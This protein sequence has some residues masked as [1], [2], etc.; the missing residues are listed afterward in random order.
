MGLEEKFEKYKKQVELRIEQLRRTIAS[1]V[2]A[3]N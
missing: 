3:M 2:E 1:I